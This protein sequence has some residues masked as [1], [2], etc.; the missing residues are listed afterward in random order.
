M[1]IEEIYLEAGL[2]SAEIASM[3]SHIKGYDPNVPD[4]FDTTAFTKLYDYFTWHTGEMPYG[5]AK[6]RDGDPETWIL[7][8]LSCE[9]PNED[10]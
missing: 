10:G 4:F 3:P 7:D 5:T 2:T 1:T 6:A 8:R 9:D